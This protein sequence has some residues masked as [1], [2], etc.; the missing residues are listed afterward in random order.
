M[1]TNATYLGVRV[2]AS[3]PERP[4]GIYPGHVIIHGD[5]WAAC[6]SEADVERDA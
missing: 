5:G 3:D 1:E 2:H 4:G 6:V